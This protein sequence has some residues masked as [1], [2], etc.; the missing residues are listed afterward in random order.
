MAAG[1]AHPR[2]VKVDLA[3]RI[4]ADFHSSE[5]AEQAAAAV[6][7]AVRARRTRPSADLPAVTIEIAEDSIGVAK[8]VVGAGLAASASDATRK[9]QQGAVRV[10]RQKITDIKARVDAG[11][12]DVILEVGRRA[13]RVTLRGPGPR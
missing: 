4:V 5:A 12:G 7:R 2:Q 8:L 6:R 1:A 11:R 13:V 9:I 10:D 3:R